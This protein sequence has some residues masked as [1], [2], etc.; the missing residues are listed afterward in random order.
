MYFD[1]SCVFL[2]SED[3][4]RMKTTVAVYFDCHYT[5]LGVAAL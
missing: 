5:M 1:T 3:T 2:Y 4:K